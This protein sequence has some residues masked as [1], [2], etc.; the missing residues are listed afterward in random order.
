MPGKRRAFKARGFAAPARQDVLR[1]VLAV[2]KGD[3]DRVRFFEELSF[4]SRSLVY[5]WSS[6]SILLFDRANDRTIGSAGGVAW[7][8]DRTLLHVGVRLTR[9]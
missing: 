1:R 7:P 9:I 8:V 2:P 3:D 4:V 5:R 6:E